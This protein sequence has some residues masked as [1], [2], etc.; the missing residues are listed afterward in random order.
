MQNN[1]NLF[2]IEIDLN[3]LG[4]YFVNVISSHLATFSMFSVQFPRLLEKKNKEV[5][6]KKKRPKFD[7]GSRS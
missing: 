3:N 5:N 6:E 4:S 2:L 1:L 7:F